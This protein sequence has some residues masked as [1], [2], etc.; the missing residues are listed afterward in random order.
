MALTLT[1]EKAEERITELYGNRKLF[2]GVETAKILGVSTS[3]VTGLKGQGILKLHETED[4]YT[5]QSIID[6]L[7][8]IKKDGR[9]VKR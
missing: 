6:R 9:K 4:Y 7:V 2:N 5:R 3:R 8:A 1:R